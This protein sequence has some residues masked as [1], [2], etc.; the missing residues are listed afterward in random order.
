MNKQEK[1]ELATRLLKQAG[2]ND[3]QI[4]EILRYTS[5]GEEPAEVADVNPD[6]GT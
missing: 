1:R 2:Y 6:Q 5:F 4:A 3:D